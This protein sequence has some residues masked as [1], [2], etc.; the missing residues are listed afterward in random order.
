[1]LAIANENK[2]KCK[3]CNAT[4][5]EKKLSK[6]SRCGKVY[7]CSKNVRKMIGTNI[8]NCVDKK[9]KISDSQDQQQQQES[10]FEERIQVHR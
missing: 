5:S 8:K 4:R 2:N 10:N 9:N 7:Y 6:C 3:R 1:M